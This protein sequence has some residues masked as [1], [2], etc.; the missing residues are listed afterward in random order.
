MTQQDSHTEERLVRIETALAHL[1]HDV[2]ELNQTLT[3][4][5]A[6]LN[7]FDKRFARIE[8]ELETLHE[9]PEQRDAEDEKPP[10]Y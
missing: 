9:A 1:Q 3:R 7:E 8:H 10:H 2:E 5:F 6:R 4:Y